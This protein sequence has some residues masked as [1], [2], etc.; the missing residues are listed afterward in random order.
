M[1]FFPKCSSP[2]STAT[3]GSDP[4]LGILGFFYH[5]GLR[6]IYG[7]HTLY[8]QWTDAGRMCSVYDTRSTSKFV[9]IKVLLL[10]LFHMIDAADNDFHRRIL[11]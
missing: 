9:Y 5:S 1:G 8:V 6:Y 3:T 4:L 11:L 10:S 2:T 7:L